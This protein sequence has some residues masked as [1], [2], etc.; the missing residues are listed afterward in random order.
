MAEPFQQMAFRDVPELPRLP[1]PY[2][3]T[4]FET[5]RVDSAHFGPMDAHVRITGSGPP[6]LLVHGFMTS[7]YSWRYVIERLSQQFTLYVPDLPGAGRSDKPD[8]SYHPDALADWIGE[9]M[10]ALGITGCRVI[11]NS[12]GGYL[13]M[14]LALRRPN[15]MSRLVNLHSPGLVTGRMRALKVGMTI[16]FSFRIVKALVHFNPELWVFKNV[17]YF[18]ESLKSRQETRE[19]AAA[20]SSNEGVRAFAHMLNETLTPATLREFE[21]TLT[22]RHQSGQ[23]FPIPLQLIYAERDPMVPPTVGRRLYALLPDADWVELQDASHFA[24]VDNPDAFL[25][26]ALRFLAGS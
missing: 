21:A 5:V 7:S 17:H 22:S 6:L 11:G 1:H 3:D 20:L 10:D 26:P 14:R 25:P 24:H 13:A 19:Y 15:A 23:S 18:D 8:V 12:M 9:L 4:P 16:P 2:F